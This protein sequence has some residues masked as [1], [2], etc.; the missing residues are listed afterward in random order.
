MVVSSSSSTLSKEEVDLSF[1]NLCQE[2]LAL[3]A[4]CTTLER[5]ITQTDSQLNTAKSSKHEDDGK[6]E[7][8]TGRLER[9]ESFA[10]KVVSDIQRKFSTDEICSNMSTGGFQSKRSSLADKVGYSISADSQLTSSNE[11]TEAKQTSSS[12]LVSGAMNNSK[13]YENGW[14][15]VIQDTVSVSQPPQSSVIMRQKSRQPNAS[16]FIFGTVEDQS[17]LSEC[18][19]S[20]IQINRHRDGIN[21]SAG[22]QLRDQRMEKYPRGD[23]L[24]QM[25]TAVY[26]QP[27]VTAG[28]LEALTVDVGAHVQGYRSVVQVPVRDS[29]VTI[30]SPQAVNRRRSQQGRDNFYGKEHQPDAAPALVRNSRQEG[31]FSEES[32]PPLPARNYNMVSELYKQCRANIMCIH[33]HL[34]I[35]N[36]MRNAEYYDSSSARFNT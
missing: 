27:K 12:Q 16:T 28:K 15:A 13:H 29:L 35:M 21:I 9:K 25:Q 32:P 18:S 11:S 22:E 24:E 23:H 17:K 10:D 4:S 36:E 5:M 26:H 1:E 30:T 31:A 14:P 19:F 7:K 3:S 20:S 2:L 33:K 8:N 6:S 34:F